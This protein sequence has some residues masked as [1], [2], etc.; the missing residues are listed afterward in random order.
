MTMRS[1]GVCSLMVAGGALIV[2]ATAGAGS[3]W[4]Q[5]SEPP[6]AEHSAT[7]EDATVPET[8][9]VLVADVPHLEQPGD[10]PADRPTHAA[11]RGSPRSGPWVRDGFVSVQV[12]VDTNGLNIP[13]DAA[14][15]PSM[16]I[17]P[18]NPDFI[19]IGWRQ[20]DTIT[21][22]FRQAG[23]G[24][25]V[26]GGQ[27]WAFTDVLQGGIFRSDPVLI[28]DSSGTFFYNSLTDNFTCDV[29]ISSDAGVTYPTVRPAFGG[30]KLWMTV[31]PTDGIGAGNLYF[32]W[33]FAAACCGTDTFTRSTDGGISY[34]SPMAI[35]LTP[36]FGTLA[37]GPE[38]ELYVAGVDQPSFSNSDFVVARSTNAQD[39]AASPVFE[40]A[41]YLSLGGSMRGARGPNPVGLLGQAW[42]A[43]DHSQSA[44]RGH[45]YMLCS[46]DP[47]GGDPLDVKFVRSI[48]GGQTWSS[49]VR[50]NDDPTGGGRWQ[51][52]GTMSVAPNGR[53]DAVWN[54]TRAN[55]GGTISELYYANSFDG[56]LSWSDNIAVSPP[57]DH[58]LG[59]PQQN[60]M[61]DYIHMYSD[62]AGARLAYTATFNSEQDV[63]FVRISAIDCNTNGVNDDQDIA[64]GTSTDCNDNLLPDECEDDCNQTG[65]PDL[66]DISDGLS[67][68]C[69]QD[70]IPDECQVQQQDCNDNGV[71]DE[72]DIS[73]GSS[74]DC[75]TNALPDECDLAAGTSVDCNQNT[76]P[77]ECDLAGGTSFDC[78]ANGV[79]DECDLA[80]GS[81]PD[82]DDNGVPDECEAPILYVDASATGE[83]FGTSWTNAYRDPQA[84]LFTASNDGAAANEIWIATGTYRPA[85]PGGNRN[86][87]FKLVEGVSLY[88]GFAGTEINRDQR[89][90]VANPTTLSGDLDGDDTPAG[91]N[92]GDNSYH[93]VTSDGTIASATLD[94]LTISGGNADDTG[95]ATYGAGLFNDG[96]S[97]T[98]SA[99]WFRSNTATYGGAV[100]SLGAGDVTL[101]NCAFGGNAADF[102]GAVFVDEGGLTMANCTLSGNS[103]AFGAGGLFKASTAQVTV[104]SCIFWENSDG[105]GA[106]ESGQIGSAGGTLAVHYTCLQGL[107]GALGGLGNIG[108]DPRLVA[109][110][111]ADGLPG[112]ADDDLH[113]APDSP[114][115]NAGDP[116]YH[117]APEVTDLDGN[118][119]LLCAR[120]DMGAYETGGPGDQDCDADVDLDDLAAWADCMTGPDAGTVSSSC[121]A[122]DFEPDDDVDLSDFGAFQGH[123]TGA[124]Q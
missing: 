66:C 124:P 34:L 106:D 117:P 59:Y 120:V 55:P 109:P 79:L 89:D 5:P 39:P 6:E 108:A 73:S 38:G 4:A 114:A 36:T 58:S 96:G 48:D 24:Y 74:F 54:D 102:G 116:S 122:F 121:A 97:P 104:N 98:I 63:Y 27:T 51:W 31:D 67:E 16:A 111:G 1:R 10:P 22:N 3:A 92:R 11:D 62:N 45:V 41:T 100:F 84:A 115:I 105:G 119:R 26:D 44:S 56:G 76:I 18:T 29:F 2:A 81:S 35:P 110:L 72:C 40:F 101:L 28:S 64:L 14:N 88:G 52:F 94:G 78:N 68:D 87:T 83:E 21:S 12:N 80:S 30:D 82:D 50:V 93:V 42:I 9:R 8:S 7:P 33:S 43:V 15:E 99:C 65:Q 77:D 46:V 13:G 57:F 32:A 23:R 103:A 61:G 69:N 60:K 53:I 37:V 20:F 123:F 25:S 75:N 113:V 95:D 70:F 86:A 17:D 85:G 90:P 107:T 19:A 112:T 71:I 91:G 49:P 118:P 47:P